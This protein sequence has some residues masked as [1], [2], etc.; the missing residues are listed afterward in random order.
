MDDRTIQA[1]LFEYIANSTTKRTQPQAEKHLSSSLAVDRRRIR[2]AIRALIQENR[3]CY[4]SHFGSGFIEVCFNRPVRIGKRILLIPAER[5]VSLLPGDLPV[6]IAAGAAFGEGG[7]PTTR[8]CLAGLER[9]LMEKKLL[10]EGAGLSGSTGL[11]IGTGSGV[12]AIA[13]AAMG[14]GRVL[15]LDTDP[16]ARDEAQRNVLLNGLADRI[17]I[18]DRPIHGLGRDSRWGRFSLILANLRYPTLAGLAS[19]IRD[20]TADKAVLVLSG[21]REDEALDLL[22]VYTDAGFAS[23]WE[24]SE[25]EWH[26]LVL[27][28]AA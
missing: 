26:G 10:S 28:K 17:E 14:V 12:L 8:L 22:S 15:G 2:R 24:S 16:C 3:L 21:F 6:R 11:D 19:I 25:K 20:I 27:A 13:A 18:D 5:T 23:L 1:V 4:T 9:A 7:H